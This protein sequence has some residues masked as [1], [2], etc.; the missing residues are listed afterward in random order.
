MEA[1]GRQR[2]RVK[3]RM[4]EGEWRGQGPDAEDPAKEGFRSGRAE[5]GVGGV[6]YGGLR[7]GENGP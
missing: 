3:E 7:S 6:G 4:E 1:S 2:G 5:E